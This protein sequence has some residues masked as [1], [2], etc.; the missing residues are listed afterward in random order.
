MNCRVPT[1]IMHSGGMSLSVALNTAGDDLLLPSCEDVA[2]TVEP[3]LGEV[4][5]PWPCSEV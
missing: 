1:V 3:R 5:P 2:A 4:T